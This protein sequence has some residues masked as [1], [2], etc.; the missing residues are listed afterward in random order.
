LRELKVKVLKRIDMK[1]QIHA[2]QRLLE[3][4]H[5]KLATHRG[6]ILVLG[7]GG[8]GQS[9]LPVILRHLD[10]SPSAVV[11]LDKEVRPEF[12]KYED[13]GVTYVHREIVK[14]NLVPTL[15]ELL[16]PGDLLINVSLN[17]DGLEIVEWCLQNNVLYIDTSIERWATEPDEIIPE[18]GERTLYTTHQEMR[19]MAS[20]YPGASTCVVTHGANPGLVSHFVKAALL[21]LAKDTG[22][23][24]GT[25]ES[26][27][28]WGMLAEALNVKIIQTA[29]R[30]TQILKEPKRVNE[31]VNTWSCEGFWAE[32]RAP[33][34]MGWGTHEKEIP[35]DGKELAGGSVL[36]LEQPGVETTVKSWVPLGGTFNG[37]L[38]QHSEAIT[39]SEYFSTENYRPTCYYAYQPCDAAIASVHEMKGQE[40][41][42]HRKTRIAKN[43][44]QSGIDELGVLLLGHERNALWYGSQLSI[45]ESR[46]L[47]EGQNATTLQVVGSMLGAIVWM[48]D[49]PN[50]GYCEPEDLPFEFVLNIASPFL[51]PIAAVYSDWTPLAHANRELYDDEHDDSDVWAF[52]N[53]RTDSGL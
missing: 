42:M 5:E 29:E 51:G 46:E 9:I 50:Q 1:V 23:K 48:L 34:E 28:Q 21:K 35:A 11:V 45:E 20:A 4:Q 43:S 30:D 37:Y 33:A 47:V 38:I 25:P 14:S 19:R 27:E 7:F 39:I 24:T 53:F 10:V 15:N 36:Y 13:L 22:L 41:W 6:H 40:L 12:A 18:L 52:S 31:F 2:A 17:I 26:Q 49:N 32:G 3:D 44:I 8:V 16:S